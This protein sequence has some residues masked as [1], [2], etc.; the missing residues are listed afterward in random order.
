MTEQDAKD[1]GFGDKLHSADCTIDEVMCL[2]LD[3]SDLKDLVRIL[4][5][6]I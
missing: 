3:L 4:D 5:K 6:A 2:P 1:L